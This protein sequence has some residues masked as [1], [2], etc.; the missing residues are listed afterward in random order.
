MSPSLTHG[1]GRSRSYE[2]MNV[3]NREAR[4][5]QSFR[6]TSL[7]S[8][9]LLKRAGHFLPKTTLWDVWLQRSSGF[10]CA[11][12]VQFE[13]MNSGFLYRDPYMQYSRGY[14]LRPAKIGI[15]MIVLRGVSNVKSVVSSPYFVIR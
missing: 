4:S 9:R 12:P 10:G 5:L 13:M 6:G 7:F 8:Q 15:L 3:F 14:R 2:T 1:G 11:T